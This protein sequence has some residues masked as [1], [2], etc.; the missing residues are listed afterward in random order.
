MKACLRAFS[1]LLLIIAAATAAAADTSEAA[2]GQP[3]LLRPA[4]V[5]TG[6]GDAAHA[7]WVVLVRNGAIAAVG[8][9]DK[10][11]VPTDARP[12]DL[13]G[14]TLVPGLIDLHAHLFLHPYNET[15]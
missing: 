6:D 9:R 1:A 15:S 4:R 2:M 3:I 8:P 14:G 12:I 7:G 5:W 10:V 11:E 13:P